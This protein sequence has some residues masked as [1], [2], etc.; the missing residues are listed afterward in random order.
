[1]LLLWR[2]PFYPFYETWL[3]QAAVAALG[4]AVGRGG[5]SVVG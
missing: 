3:Q 2:S 4:C 1:M 5:V